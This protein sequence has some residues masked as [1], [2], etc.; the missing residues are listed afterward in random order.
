MPKVAQPI[1]NVSGWYTHEAGDVYLR[2]AGTLM[3]G[4]AVEF[5]MIEVWAEGQRLGTALDCRVYS[6]HERLRLVSI[7][8]ALGYLAD[9]RRRVQGM[10]DLERRAMKRAQAELVEKYGA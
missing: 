3:G 10:V 1:V 7:K 5:T 9:K 8:E 6:Y 2:Y 4:G